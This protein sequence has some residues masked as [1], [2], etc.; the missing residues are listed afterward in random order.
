MTIQIFHLDFVAIHFPWLYLF[1]AERVTVSL[2][3][4]GIFRLLEF[5]VRHPPFGFAHFAIDVKARHLRLV[6][7]LPFQHIFIFF[8]HGAESGD[9]D[10]GG[11]LQFIRANVAIIRAGRRHKIHVARK[12]AL[13]ETTCAKVR[14]ADGFAAI[15]VR[16]FVKRRAAADERERER[17]VRIAVERQRSVEN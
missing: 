9:V 13:V 3:V 16:R 11:G 10:G 2:R 4:A 5:A 15:G 8:R 12:G 17:A 6:R 14:R 7:R 1:I